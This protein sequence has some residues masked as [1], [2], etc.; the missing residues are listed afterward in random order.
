M[1]IPTLLLTTLQDVLSG[2]IRQSIAVLFSQP[3]TPTLFGAACALTT[4]LDEINWNF[5]PAAILPHVLTTTAIYIGQS[6]S[7]TTPIVEIGFGEV[8]MQMN[9]LT[10]LARLAWSG[11]LREAYANASS[12]VK[13]W[14][15][16]V[17]PVCEEKIGKWIEKYKIDSTTEEEVGLS[18]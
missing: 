2:G 5:F 13:V 4:S 16:V 15:S 1:L 14:E 12:A 10:L 11:R 18:R 7:T 6:K 8:S 3:T 17:G 9:A